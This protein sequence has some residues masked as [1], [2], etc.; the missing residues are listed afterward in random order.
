MLR[1]AS[2]RPMRVQN[3][4]YGSPDTHCNRL[5]GCTRYR[6]RQQQVPNNGD[7]V[8]AGASTFQTSQA[9]DASAQADLAAIAAPVVM[10]QAAQQVRARAAARGVQAS[11]E[12]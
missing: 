10:A 9:A 7:A 12:A 1:A 4:N 6:L 5:A 8:K 2:G 11:Q 3:T